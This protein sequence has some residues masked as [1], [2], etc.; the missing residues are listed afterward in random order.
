MNGETARRRD[1]RA[2]RT[3]NTLDA[4]DVLDGA[5]EA[6]AEAKQAS[7]TAQ[8]ANQDAHIAEV[9]AERDAER[10][11]AAADQALDAAEV[12]AC[13]ATRSALEADALLLD[14]DAQKVAA[15]VSEEQP[16][17]LPGKPLDRRSLVRAGFTVT[18]GGLL[19]VALG[20]T[21]V[22][23]EQELLIIV[24]A[25][26]IA[27]GLEPAVT[28]LTRRHL[29]RWAAVLVISLL[30]VGLVAAFL[31]AAVPPLVNEAT[32]LIKH[33]P[34]YLQQL[35]D[36]HTF[37]GRLNA[38]FHLTDKLNTAANQKLSISSFGG[39]LSVGM[40]IISFTFEAIIVLVLV[41]YILAD[42]DG[43]KR[44]FYR[45][46]P[47]HRRP[48]VAL[49]TDEILARIGGYILGNLLT[50]LIAIICQYIILRALG[51]PYALVLS[52]FVGLLDLVPLVGSTV[53]G[54]SRH[55]GHARDRVVDRRDHQRRV[56]HPLPPRRGL[57]HQPPC[58]QTHRRRPPAGHRRR[59]APRRG[60]AGHHRRA[61]RRP[62]RRGDPTHPHRSRLPPHGPRRHPEL[63]DGEFVHPAQ[64]R[65]DASAQLCNVKTR[66]AACGCDG[67]RTD[68][69][70][71]YR[72]V[73]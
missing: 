65:L 46:V 18:F 22:A 54:V 14:E 2:P 27:V 42:F 70:A 72:L 73:G 33:G 24:V 61:D 17:G 56:H 13:E 57:P 16:F 10:A 28:W 25:T 20:A 37:I 6:T 1:G 35:Q 53:A 68:R 34:Q 5:R 67:R 4:A 59:R 9:D 48:R 38:Q 51:V 58:P 31:A 8:S 69:W 32:Q 44:V 63:T 64:T 3:V 71:Q 40:A 12:A 62:R 11:Q 21:I 7:E 49:L 55:R 43:I 66:I 47:L 15:Q 52:V 19:A 29:P 23:L 41:L 50:S 36:K 60:A 26:F 45:M 30:S 39:L